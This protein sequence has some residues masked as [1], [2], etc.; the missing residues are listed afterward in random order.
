MTKSNQQFHTEGGKY[1]ETKHLDIKDIA[2]LIRLDIKDAVKSGTLP[3]TKY[4]VS[5]AR[6]AG[7]QSLYISFN[8]YVM[9]I[10]ERVKTK[11]LLRTIGDNYNYDNSDSMTDY[12]SVNFF[13]HVRG[14]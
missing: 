4:R 6:Y 10:P 12:Y 1:Q 9:I 13:L 2:K 3:E 11:Q 8:T 14:E 5:I 7:G